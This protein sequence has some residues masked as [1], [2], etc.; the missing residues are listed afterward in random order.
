VFGAKVMVKCYSCGK[1]SKGGM[2]TAKIE[3]EERSY[4][5]DCYW[6]VEKEYKSKKSCEDCSYFSAEKCKKK[7]KELE[8][9]TVGYATYFV[10]AEGCG[11]YSTDR[12]V[13]VAEIRK[14]EESGQFGEAAV[15]YDK[16]GMTEEAE[17]ARG[18]IAQQSFS[19]E[20]LVT[21]L[22][23]QGKTLTY[24]C[25]HC[26]APLKVGSKA[27]AKKK[28]PSCKG[29]LGVI[30]LGMLIRQHQDDV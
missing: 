9:V 14:L 29:D 24:Y 16:L 21:D 18:K 12:D 30:N 19:T 11:N 26:G 25:P 6:K 5:A 23:K 27:E 15:G 4:C 7:G 28:C 8:P 2:P 22:A 20:G 3:G 10:Q 13:A 17:A 1:T